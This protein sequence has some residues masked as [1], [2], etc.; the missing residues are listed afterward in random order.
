[1]GRSKH[2]HPYLGKLR[3]LAASLPET[4]ERETWEHPTFRVRDKIFASF[5]AHD[6]RPTIGCKQTHEDQA[7]LVEESGFEVAP[8]VGQHGWIMI[9]IDEVKWPMVADLVDASYRLIAPKKL[10]KELDAG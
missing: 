6:G 2:K 1:M 5:G 7:I 9:Y 10:V 4:S 3:K 8:Y